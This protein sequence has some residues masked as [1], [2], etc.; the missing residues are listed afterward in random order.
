MDRYAASEEQ[1]SAG[2]NLL[3]PY[4]DEAN[5][6]A[7]QKLSPG[8]LIKRLLRRL[9]F[10]L[11]DYRVN[12][13]VAQDR[14]APSTEVPNSIQV[15]VP[16]EHHLLTFAQHPDAKVSSALSYERAGYR[17]FVLLENENPACLIH[18]ADL[19]K[20]DSETT[21]PLA[22]DEIALANV[23]T[24]PAYRCGGLASHLIADATA[25]LVPE[26]YR[27]AIA[28]IWWNHDA[29]L[30]AFKAAGWNRIGLSIEIS[31]R[32]GRWHFFHIPLRR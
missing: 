25:S 14:L 30:R 11:V 24:L 16:V 2:A 7:A 26:H 5:D 13:I 8:G 28:Y 27:R 31:R 1:S 17:S 22:E 9:L 15:S 29:S 4:T 6:V 32:A 12:W 18:F 10:D 20:Y 21:W 23:I 3:A 19:A